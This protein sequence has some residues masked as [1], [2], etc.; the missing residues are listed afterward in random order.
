MAM[1][2]SVLKAEH[3]GSN[4]LIKDGARLIDSVG[5]VLAACFPHVQPAAEKPVEL[6]SSENKVYSLIGFEKTRR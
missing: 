6:D 3:A 4:R 5:D 2:G 1:P